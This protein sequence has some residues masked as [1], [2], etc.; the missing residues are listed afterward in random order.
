VGLRVVAAA[1]PHDPPLPPAPIAMP[2]TPA[3]DGGAAS[4]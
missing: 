1:E 2:A 4:G 3:E